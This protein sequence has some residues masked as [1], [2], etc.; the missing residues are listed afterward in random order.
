MNTFYEPVSVDIA[1]TKVKTRSNLMMTDTT[2][3]YA[4]QRNGWE[5]VQLWY[6][7]LTSVFCLP[8]AACSHEPQQHPQ[9]PGKACIHGRNMVGITISDDTVST[10]I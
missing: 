10:F 9:K 6:H 5:A 1:R 3:Q 7:A 4:A 8:P 2:R